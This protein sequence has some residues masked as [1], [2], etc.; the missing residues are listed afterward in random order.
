MQYTRWFWCREKQ[1]IRILVI[2][3]LLLNRKELES[4]F[5]MKKLR[6]VDIFPMMYHLHHS[7]ER[8]EK[9]YEKTAAAT[10]HPSHDF[11]N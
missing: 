4:V 6:L 1:S 9:T 8:F 3:K 2:L 10:H 11:Q 5:Y 7:A